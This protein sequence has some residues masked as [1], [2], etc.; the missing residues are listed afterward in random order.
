MYAVTK[1]N[2]T[3]DTVRGRY[4]RKKEGGYTALQ[5]NFFII[6]DP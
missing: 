2:S 3:N 1:S 4:T 5:G 6:V